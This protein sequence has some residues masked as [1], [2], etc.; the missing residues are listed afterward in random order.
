MQKEVFWRWL[1]FL[2]PFWKEG[3]LSMFHTGATLPTG[4][5]LTGDSMWF[6]KKSS[7]DFFLKLISKILW[8][9]A[10][11]GEGVG[12][13]L[14]RPVLII[15]QPLVTVSSSITGVKASQFHR[16]GTDSQRRLPRIRSDDM[17]KFPLKRLRKTSPC[18]DEMLCDTISTRDE[19]SSWPVSGICSFRN[20]SSTPWRKVSSTFSLSLFFK[21]FFSIINILFHENL[22]LLRRM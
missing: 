17:Q 1:L 16:M 22:L 12:A 15:A 6:E 4:A 18:A 19:A 5:I 11:R 7:H 13:P 21:I 14:G 10:D 20:R 3:M 8:S 9:S 2:K